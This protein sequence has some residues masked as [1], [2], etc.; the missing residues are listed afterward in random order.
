MNFQI[1]GGARL[2]GKVSTNSSKNSAVALLQAALLNKNK[3]VLRDVPRIEEVN[4]II[5][6]LK[7][8]GVSV[9]WINKHDVEIK[10]DEINLESINR[11]A[12]MMT[13]SVILLLGP[14]VHIKP[15][16]K[17]P[18][19]GGCKLGS[20]TVRPHLFAL[21]DFGVKI[22]TLSDSYEVS[23]EKLAPADVV[24]YESGDTATENAIMTA[25]KIEGTTTIKFASA[26]YQI[27]D[28]CFFLQSLGVGIEGVGTTTLKITGRREID[29]PVEFFVS[30]DPIESMLFISIAA[31]TSSSIII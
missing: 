14:L 15:H 4:R 30:E 11:E 2:S 16:F 22:K 7:S 17:I 13:R 20:R 12:A 1:E 6:V 18:Q 27:Q 10:P 31:T 26:N 25:A 29:A 9:K 24:L 28:L 23:A 5:E 3:T 8:I 19:P 21:E